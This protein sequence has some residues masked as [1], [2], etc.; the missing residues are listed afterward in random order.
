MH[1]PLLSTVLFAG[2]AVSSRLYTA[3]YDGK[4]TELYLSNLGASYQL[5]VRTQTSG[6]GASPSW[7]MVDGENDIIYCLNES[8]GGLNEQ[9]QTIVGPVASALYTTANA[10]SRRFFAVAHYAGSTVTSYAVDP[11]SGLFNHSQTFSYTMSRPG[12]V[13]SRQEAH[14]PHGVVVDPTGNF[15]LVPD[16]GADLVRI[17]RINATTG[18]LEEQQPLTVTPGSGPRHAVFWS[19]KQ[20]GAAH[21][22]RSRFYLVTELDNGLRG[23]DVS[24]SGNGA[25]LFSQFYEENTYGGSVPPVESK[26]AEIAISPS[27]DR[28]VISNRGDATYG[29][30]NDSVALFSLPEQDQNRTVLFQGLT[31][32][33]GAFPRH[34]QFSP[35]GSMLAIALQNSNKV[36]VAAWDRKKKV[37]GPLLSEATLGGEV[38][39]VVWGP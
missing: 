10:S 7:L 19:P 4:V 29:P 20:S 31:P 13:P 3:S 12:P 6:C 2:L 5:S 37:L 27:N 11:I 26:A 39:A 9:L 18:H 25:I 16:L 28:L 21:P 1:L 23:Y 15:V 38:T 30:R 17:Y 22:Q 36:A 32:A 33:Y 14:H 24:Y 34:F 8:V 35:D